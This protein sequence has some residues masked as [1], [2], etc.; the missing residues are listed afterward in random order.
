MT[1]WGLIRVRCSALARTPALPATPRAGIYIPRLVHSVSGFPSCVDIDLACYCAVV[2]A[3]LKRL[4]PSVS[5]EEM[6]V[7]VVA[8]NPKPRHGIPF[9]NPDRPIAPGYSDRPDMFFVI[10]ALKT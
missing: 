8:P 2:L 10:D 3:I 6:L 9:Q 4:S 1:T 7:I 5:R